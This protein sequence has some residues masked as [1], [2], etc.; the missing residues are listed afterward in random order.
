MAELTSFDL[1]KKAGAAQDQAYELPLSDPRRNQ[2]L[3]D[4]HA[5]LVAARKVREKAWKI[6]A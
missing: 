5:Y 4:C 2:L 3:L 6:H 1:V